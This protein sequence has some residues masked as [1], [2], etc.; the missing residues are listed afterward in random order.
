MRV[1][2]GVYRLDP[3]H[4]FAEF[5][6]MHLVVSRVDGR[7]NAIEGEFVVVEESEQLFDR[8]S[9]RVEAAS[10]DTKVAAR[11]EDLRSPR[12]FDVTNYPAL[13]FRGV[14]SQ[15]SD[16]SVWVVN[17]DLTIRDVTRP[18]TLEV[19]VQ[20]SAVDAHGNTKIGLTATTALAR[21][22]FDLTTELLQEPGRTGVLESPTP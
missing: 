13:G 1:P 20:G 14:D 5:R 8:V 11:D 2:P 9:A 7:F 3:A 15:R 12:F 18:I 17:G 19:V 4:T 10:V 6:V 21:S 22:E 16:D